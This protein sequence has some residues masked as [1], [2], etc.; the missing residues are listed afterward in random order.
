[1]I[2]GIYSITFTI[3]DQDAAKYRENEEHKE[4][5]Q[6]TQHNAAPEQSAFERLFRVEGKVVDNGTDGEHDKNQGKKMTNN[7][8]L[9][10]LSFCFNL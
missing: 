2:Q 7:G 10:L 4:R 6:H 9:F 5:H 1:M 3:C 8:S